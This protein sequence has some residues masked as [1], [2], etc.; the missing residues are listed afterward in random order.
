[1]L[2]EKCAD[3]RGQK[4]QPILGE[5]VK[6]LVSPPHLVGLGISGI[7]RRDGKPGDFDGLGLVGVRR[8]FSSRNPFLISADDDD[9]GYVSPT[10]IRV[11]NREN[12]KRDEQKLDDEL[13][14]TFMRELVFTWETDHSIH[15]S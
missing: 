7:S 8:S 12:D 4:E 5:H 14:E 1:M 2:H 11:H 9:D 3:S 6:F 13:S 10:P 15:G